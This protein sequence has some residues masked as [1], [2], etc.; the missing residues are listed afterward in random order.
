MDNDQ[1]I[2]LLHSEVKPALGCT[3]PAA[4]AFTVARARQLL[5]G[6]VTQVRVILSSNV[7]K[8]AL[9][10]CI[11]PV[12]DTGPGIRGHDSNCCGGG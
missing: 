11:P 6:S 12:G 9:A 1:L 8:N 3:E 5:E 10:V 4:I 2:S 7:Y